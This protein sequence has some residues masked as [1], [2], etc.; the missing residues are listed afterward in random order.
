[1]LC[2]EWD[3]FNDSGEDAGMWSTRPGKVDRCGRSS[4][5][6]PGEGRH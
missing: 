3:G 1:M 5:F 6:D 2:G 4:G